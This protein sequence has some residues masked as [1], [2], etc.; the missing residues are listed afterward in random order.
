MI[1]SVVV[2]KT[3]MEVLVSLTETISKYI[4]THFSV[5]SNLF[6]Y[7]RVELFVTSV[8]MVII[9]SVYI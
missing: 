4:T 1:V 8:Q 2:I 6:H 7:A 5:I 3:A 9:V